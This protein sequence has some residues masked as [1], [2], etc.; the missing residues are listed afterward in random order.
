MI[1]RFALFLLVLA[2]GSAIVLLGAR[3]LR[4]RLKPPSEAEMQR[5][6]KLVHALRG[7]ELFKSQ[8]KYHEPRGDLPPRKAGSYL[9][10]HDLQKIKQFLRG[11]IGGLDDQNTESTEGEQASQ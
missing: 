3:D 7:D 9:P 6:S 2:F 5:A 1:N 11:L 8:A 10:E 4:D